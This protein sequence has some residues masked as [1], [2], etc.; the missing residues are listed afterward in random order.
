MLEIYVG[1]LVSETLLFY[2][3]TQVQPFVC[4]LY[5]S[6]LAGDTRTS[7]R[8]NTRQQRMTNYANKSMSNGT[9]LPMVLQSGMCLYSTSTQVGLQKIIQLKG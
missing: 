9:G 2:C 7:C 6:S 8:L 3:I 5:A 4:C 1:D